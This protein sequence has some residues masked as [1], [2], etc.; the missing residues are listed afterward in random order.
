MSTVSTVSPG[1]VR[2]PPAGRVNLVSP[3]NPPDKHFE[4][5]P[6]G[7]PLTVA[8]VENRSS[9]YLG[10]ECVSIDSTRTA[11]HREELEGSDGVDRSGNPMGGVGWWS[12]LHVS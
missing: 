5:H 12:V 1:S 11:G 4:K 9:D 3:C 8:L 6:D 7:Y 10:L 2:G